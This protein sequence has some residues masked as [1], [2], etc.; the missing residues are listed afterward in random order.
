MR[1]EHVIDVRHVTKAYN[2]HIAVDDL[3]FELVQGEIFAFLGPNG[4]GKTTTMRMILDI[5]R[6]DSGEIAVF[7]G[8]LTDAAKNRIGYMPEER[9]LY[10]NVPLMELMIYLGALK[11]MSAADARARATTLLERLDL[12]EYLTKKVSELSKGMQQ[13]A[14]FVATILHQPELIIVDEPFSGLDP[15]N[16]RLLKDM[17]FDLKREGASIL[18]STHMMHQVEEMGDRLLMIDEGRCVLYGTLDE[19]RQRFAENAILV[20]G[21]GDWASVPGVTRVDAGRNGSDARLHL[22]EGVTTDQV[23]QAIAASPAHRLTGFQLAV[24]SLEEIF[25]QVAGRGLNGG[26]A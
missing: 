26:G 5:L 15:V 8:P 2:S 10:R 16:S 20:Q 9:G 24:P 7:G 3:S 1:G 25:V 6:P 11:G 21:E 14:Q 18:M 13:K 22:A 4:S 17:L 19:V 12:G 23:M